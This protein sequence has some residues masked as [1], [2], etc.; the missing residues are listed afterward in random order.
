MTDLGQHRRNPV[1]DAMNMVRVQ[2]GLLFLFLGSMPILMHVVRIAQDGLPAS[3]PTTIFIAATVL[4]VAG[5]AVTALGML[6][7]VSAAGWRRVWLG[8]GMQILACI[9]LLVLYANIA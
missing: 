9:A 3:L 5:A 8:G 7:A 1:N 2:V 4:G 6:P